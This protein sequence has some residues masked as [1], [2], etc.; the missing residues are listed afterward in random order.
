MDTVNDA[1]RRVMTAMA[2]TMA[3]MKAPAAAQSPGDEGPAVAAGGDCHGKSA[4]QSGRSRSAMTFVATTGVRPFSDYGLQDVGNLVGAIDGMQNPSGRPT[5]AATFPVVIMASFSPGELFQ[6]LQDGTS[7]PV[8]PE[9]IQNGLLLAQNGGFEAMFVAADNAV[10]HSATMLHQYGG[11]MTSGERDVLTLNQDGLEVVADYAS[12]VKD[13]AEDQI[14]GVTPGPIVLV[15]GPA[16]AVSAAPVPKR[17]FT[18]KAISRDMVDLIQK[19]VRPE[20]AAPACGGKRTAAWKNRRDLIMTLA[21]D[22]MGSGFAAGNAAKRTQFEQAMKI[23]ASRNGLKLDDPKY[24][25]VIAYF[26][27]LVA[28]NPSLSKMVQIGGGALRIRTPKDLFSDKP[29]ISQLIGV[30]HLLTKGDP[31]KQGLVGEFLMAAAK[32][33]V[34]LQ[35]PRFGAIAKEALDLIASNPGLFDQDTLVAKGDQVS[36]SL[37]PDE[38]ADLE[39]FFHFMG[40][41]QH[42][43]AAAKVLAAQSDAGRALDASITASSSVVVA[44]S[45]L[46]AL[47]ETGMA[48]MP[49]NDADGPATGKPA[50]VDV[51]PVEPHG[52]AEDGDDH[53]SPHGGSGP[54]GDTVSAGTRTVLPPAPEAATA[55]RDG[56]NQD[57]ATAL[58]NA[59]HA[60]AQARSERH[61][62]E[63]KRQAEIRAAAEQADRDY[64]A[65]LSKQRQ[66]LDSI[67]RDLET[68]AVAKVLQPDGSQKAVAVDRQNRVKVGE[69]PI[70]E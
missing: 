67:S 28:Q 54:V 20:T 29:R 56:A 9:V 31:A 12:D 11:M 13:R 68:A 1:E 19:A 38:L 6:G 10:K 45:L 36:L 35:D 4:H 61:R 22:F 33:P 59:D 46:Y 70:N 52:H 51:E 25:D 18:D 50:R 57:V 8:S 69:T 14:A 42:S 60:L 3:A 66:R 44:L 43:D 7:T 24:K 64:D 58:R 2:P 21:T 17:A 26:Q 49:L 16:G 27:R 30:T 62:G 37:A 65:A 47:A 63:S 5:T 32:G 53:G 23:A 34:S 48:P 55:A 15:G 40:S 41:A 39:K